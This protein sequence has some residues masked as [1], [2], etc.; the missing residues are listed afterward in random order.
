[1]KILT[2]GDMHLGRR[3]SRLPEQL[4]ERAHELGPASAWKRTVDAALDNRVHAVLLAGDVVENENDFFEAYRDLAGGV[5]RLTDDGIDVVGVAGNHDVK[6][7][8]RLAEQIPQFKL[9]G[10]DGVWEPWTL[11]D[12]G[13]SLTLWGWSFPQAKVQQSPLVNASFDRRDGLNLGLLHCDRDAGSSP[14]AP[15]SSQDMEL[16]RLDGWLL[17]HIHK[18]DELTPQKPIGYLGSLTG[19][20]RSE[21]GARGPWLI[22]IER[23]T[24]AEVTHL[25]LAPLRWERLKLDIEDI[26]EPDDAKS[27]LVDRL[28]DFDEHL[29]N[30]ASTPDAVG[31]DVHLTGRTRLGDAARSALTEEDLGYVHAG[32][33]SRHYF[34]HRLTIGTRPEFE[35]TQLAERENP[36]GLLAQRLIWLQ[37]PEGHPNRDQLV[38]SAHKRLAKVANQAVWSGLSET[39]PDPLACLIEAGYRALDQLLTQAEDRE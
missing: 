19:L 29:D 36:L 31:L 8:P 27:R 28:R 4:S 2:V 15:V 23:G 16:S 17:G 30:M 13:E 39:P 22:R 21:T 32:I 1:M 10:R 5:Q 12:G 11:E 6:V 37:E 14:Y 9:L 18:P 38:V 7:L 3:P 20:R 35:L 34:I 33:G 25:P 24:L 26:A